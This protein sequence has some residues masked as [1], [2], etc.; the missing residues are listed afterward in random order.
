MELGSRGRD[1][2]LLNGITRR[3]GETCTECGDKE[4][5]AHERAPGRNLWGLGTETA[6]RSTPPPHVQQQPPLSE[7][8]ETLRETEGLGAAAF[9]DKDA[10][11]VA[12]E[13][14]PSEFLRSGGSVT[15]PSGRKRQLATVGQ[16]HLQH[17]K[18]RRRQ[19][20]TVSLPSLQHGRRMFSDPCLTRSAVRQKRDL[21]WRQEGPPPLK[22]GGGV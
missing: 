7:W 18:R 5:Y 20:A 11:S 6:S 2:P 13:R 3:T 21:W 15:S 9:T 10:C 14:A 22:N 12:T 1:C 19:L 16:P 17:G 4:H 8:P